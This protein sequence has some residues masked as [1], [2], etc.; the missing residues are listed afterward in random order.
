MKV[1]T[2]GT[3]PVGGHYPRVDWG[4]DVFPTPPMLD[5]NFDDGLPNANGQKGGVR[6]YGGALPKVVRWDEAADN[7]PPDFDNMP[8][9]NVSERAKRVIESVEPGVHQF[10]PVE[11]IDRQDQPIETRYW[12]YI[13]NRRDTIH[14]TKSNMLLNKWGEYIPPIDAVRRKLEIP[15]H[16]DTKS[17]GK[18]VID[19]SKIGSEHMWC[20]PR[21][22]GARLMSE[23]MWQAMQIA[24]LTGMQPKEIETV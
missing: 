23:A 13:C 7:P 20:E 18:I 1:Y 11:Y 9:M 24:G 6:V 19:S 5:D 8:T 4:E 16:V 17:P 22:E 14:P 15:P 2:V 10:F 21:A 12:F 3:K